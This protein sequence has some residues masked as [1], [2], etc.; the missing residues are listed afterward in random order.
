MSLSLVYSRAVFSWFFLIIAMITSGCNM[1][2]ESSKSGL[3]WKKQKVK[4]KNDKSGDDHTDLK[5]NKVAPNRT[6]GINVNTRS[7]NH[8]E[9]VKVDSYKLAYNTEGDSPKANSKKIRIDKMHTVKYDKKSSTQDKIENSLKVLLEFE[10]SFKLAEKRF[11]GNFLK[12]LLIIL[13]IITII[14]GLIGGLF[15]GSVTGL[16]VSAI[17]GFIIL[18]IGLAM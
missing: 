9:Q 1:T 17:P 8:I 2:L 4:V 7:S 6:P 5:F 16:I 10:Q 15:T 14:L 18:L 13:G 11:T 3:Y 12:T